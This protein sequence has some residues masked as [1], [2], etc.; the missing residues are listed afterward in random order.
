LRFKKTGFH[1][2]FDFS[3]QSQIEIANFDAWLGNLGVS[4]RTKPGHSLIRK[5]K[6]EKKEAG[7]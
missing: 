7:V 5:N 4:F 6:R 2:S 1:T 3:S